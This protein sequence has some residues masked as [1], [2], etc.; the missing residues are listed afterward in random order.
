M[1]IKWMLYKSIDFGL[2]FSSHFVACMTK[3]LTFA[4]YFK[5]AIPSLINGCKRTK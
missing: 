3:K 5:R 1:I 2:P 4:P